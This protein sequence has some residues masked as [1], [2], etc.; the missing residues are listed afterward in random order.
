MCACDVSSVSSFG[1]S[2][3]FAVT[4]HVRTAL[5]IQLECDEWANEEKR[6]KRK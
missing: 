4:F 3:S 1:V 2:S 6:V 5:A